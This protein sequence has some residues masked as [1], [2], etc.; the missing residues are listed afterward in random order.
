MSNVGARKP[1]E[2]ALDM[3]QR[4]LQIKWQDGHISQYGF[5]ALRRACPCAE[6]RPW[7]HGGGAVGVMPDK[8]RLATGDIVSPQDVSFV[9]SYALNIHFADGHTTGIYTWPYLRDICPCPDHT[10]Q[11]AA[12]QSASDL[13]QG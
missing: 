2:I 10:A 8:V 11:R 12:A 9:G 4:I 1:E 13:R 6:C 3:T 5:D 7:T